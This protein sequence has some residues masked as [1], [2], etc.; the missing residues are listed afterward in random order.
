MA[1]R[2]WLAV[3]REVEDRKEQGPTIWPR[4]SALTLDKMGACLTELRDTL[5][6]QRINAADCAVTSRAYARSAPAHPARYA[7]R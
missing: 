6:N 1:S 2:R 3:H 4:A 5:A 7:Q